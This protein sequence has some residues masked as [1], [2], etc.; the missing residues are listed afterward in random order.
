[1]GLLFCIPRSLPGAAIAKAHR[2]RYQDHGYWRFEDIVH[3]STPRT[4]T[5]TALRRLKNRVYDPIRHPDELDSITLLSASSHRALITFWTTSWCPSCTAV[6]TTI[7]QVVEEDGAAED[8]GGIGYSEVQF[9]SPTLGDLPQRYM[10]TT[11][12]T[13]MAFSRQEAQIETRLSNLERMKNKSALS[14]WIEDEAR[15]GAVGGRGGKSV[16]GGLFRYP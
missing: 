9:D 5:L 1:M 12:P 13:L 14:Q 8:L 7:R 3:A 6:A 2:G 16:L 10:I 15:R 4:F 11:I